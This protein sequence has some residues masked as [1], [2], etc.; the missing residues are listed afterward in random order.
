MKA[1]AWCE[2]I[3]LSSFVS[4][5]K[6]SKIRRKYIIK[7]RFRERAFSSEPYFFALKQQYIAMPTVHLEQKEKSTLILF[8][9]LDKKR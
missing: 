8:A 9:H 7:I 6:L 5:G 3:V 4:G 2:T 1:A